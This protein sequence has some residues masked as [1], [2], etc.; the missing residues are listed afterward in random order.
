M[1]DTLLTNNHVSGYLV[2]QCIWS[3][4]ESGRLTVTMPNRLNVAFDFSAFLKVHLFAIII[5]NWLLCYLLFGS[6]MM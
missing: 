3:V 1:I 5:G 2:Y 6:D 4:A